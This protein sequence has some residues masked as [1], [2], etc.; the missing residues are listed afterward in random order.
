MKDFKSSLKGI[1]ALCH[2]FRGR[3]F[4]SVM[5]GMLQVAA[6]T[7]FV[8]IS[9]HLIDIV[10]NEADG[11][12][13][14]CVWILI[15]IVILRIAINVFAS[16]WENISVAIAQNKMRR[17]AFSHLLRSRWNGR[18]VYHSADAVNRIYED[19]RV[20]VDLVCVQIPD[21][22]IACCQLLAASVILVRMAPE[23]LGMLVI[24]MLVGIVGARLFFRTQRRISSEIR[25]LDSDS[26]RH[27]Q[28]N[29]QNR[30]VVLS[31]IGID[32]VLEKFKEIQGKLLSAFRRRLGYNSISRT[33]LSFGFMAGYTA[34]F[35]WGIFGI[36]DGVVTYG[37]M[38]AFLQLVGQVQRPLA[39]L[40]KNVSKFIQSLASEERFDDLKAL[41]EV[42][43]FDGELLKEA[44]GIVFDN[45]TFAYQDMGRPVL[46]AFSYEFRAGSL[47][48]ITGETGCGKSTLVRLAMG[49]LMPTSGNV[50]FKLS[51]KGDTALSMSNFMYV[52]QDNCLLSGTI[53]ENLLLAA[54]QA[55]EDEMRDALHIA[56]ADFVFKLPLGLDTLC[57]EGGSGISRGQAQRI[58]I[59]RALLHD[60]TVLILD[61]ATS[62]LDDET[63]NIFLER[64]SE[65][66]RHKKTILFVS[67]RGRIG[68]FA[69]R[70][71][72]MD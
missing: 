68:S 40:A 2:Q 16:Y 3:I 44:P 14:V 28:D 6:S 56:A 22:T 18:E 61:E 62:A 58:A 29:L 36:R 43:W 12:L 60:G 33:F 50:R 8:L 57:G 52:P 21:I 24:L 26:Q 30:S 27:I 15:G 34:A 59:A 63:E 13:T 48:V 32:N 72:Q 23:L 47:T 53:R 4:V 51:D 69:D 46:K 70:N 20:L 25:N 39:D 65:R 10:T 9:K 54:P 71:L 42:D 1:A 17:D 41:P 67:H 31:Q 49:L 5:M 38:T 45:V 66:Y 37:M 7:A 55:T 35:L 64:L 19:I 11:S